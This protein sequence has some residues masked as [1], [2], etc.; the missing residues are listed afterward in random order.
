MLLGPQP[1]GRSI[2]P[3]YGYPLAHFMQRTVRRPDPPR[4]GE[5][6]GE[7]AVGCAGQCGVWGLTVEESGV[8]W[9]HLGLTLRLLGLK[10]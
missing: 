7:Y 3:T 2:R 9:R 10:R 8:Q 5:Y 6:A 4:P 1:G